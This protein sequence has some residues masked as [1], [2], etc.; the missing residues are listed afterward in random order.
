MDLYRAEAKR[1]HSGRCTSWKAK[2]RKDPNRAIAQAKRW[3]QR[4]PFAEI[5][6]VCSN[7]MKGTL[8]HLKAAQSSG[9]R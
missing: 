1:R 4:E 8:D 6:I 5:S 2:W 3:R 7:G 9:K